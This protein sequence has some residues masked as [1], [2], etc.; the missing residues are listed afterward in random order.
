MVDIPIT[1]ETV[2]ATFVHDT[3]F[4]STHEDA[5]TA[6]EK[7][8]KS[9]KPFTILAQEI[10][11]QS[12][13]T[14]ITFITKWG[15]CPKVTDQNKSKI[16]RTS[17]LIVY[18]FFQVKQNNSLSNYYPVKSGVPQGNFLGTYLY[19]I[20]TVDIPVTANIIIAIFVNDTAF[21]STHENLDTTCENLLNHLNHLQ[22]W[23][24]KWRTKSNGPQRLLL[25]QNE[26]HV[27]K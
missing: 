15:T 2:I 9:S 13:S 10:E 7:S 11:D 5:D 1:D 4:L 21:L 18:A 3:A 22:F 24:R 26:V 25:L 19:L 6:R 27:Q 23:L 16:S 17:P 8:P 14:Y 12:K 20:Y